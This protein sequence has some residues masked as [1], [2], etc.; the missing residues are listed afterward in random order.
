MTAMSGIK[1]CLYCDRPIEG[2]AIKVG[3]ADAHAST[4]GARPDNWRHLKGDPACR[5]TT[6]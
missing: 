5:A 6:H 2:V 4:S 3:Q 1:I